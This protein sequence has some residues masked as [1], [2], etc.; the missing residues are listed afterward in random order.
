MKSGRKRLL[1]CAA[2]A[3]VAAICLIY[4]RRPGKPVQDE[5]VGAPDCPFRV[6]IATEGTE[7]KM[8]VAAGV[9]RRL[10]SRA[11]QVKITDVRRLDDGDAGGYDAV[12]ILSSVILGKL[13]K[14]AH[15][16]LAQDGSRGRTIVVATATDADWLLDEPGLDACTAASRKQD[17]EPLAADIAGKIRRRLEINDE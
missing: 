13:H 14:A 8:D 17:A 1:Q 11:C 15:W 16:W 6:L 4:L 12:V 9:A 2:V 7:F 3:A 10:T 5:L